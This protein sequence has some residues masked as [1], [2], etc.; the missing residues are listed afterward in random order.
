[1]IG[2]FWDALERDLK[3]EKMGLESTTEVVGEP[4]LSF[5]YDPKRS[6]YEQFSRAARESDDD[7][8]KS[9]ESTESNTDGR[10]S[11]DDMDT[12]ES[13]PT[14]TDVKDHEADT[15]DVRMSSSPD[16]EDGPKMRPGSA[17]L[18][19]KRSA[20]YF[21]AQYLML[22]E[23]NQ[24]SPNYKIRK[25]KAG[26]KGSNGL[27]SGVVSSARR[28]FD[29]ERAR[30]HGF[31]G[32][33]DGGMMLQFE[34]EI[35]REGDNMNA[36]EMFRLQALGELAPA[37]GKM[38][39]P[40]PQPMV[41][42]AEVYYHPSS[43]IQGQPFLTGHPG[44][45]MAHQ[46][47]RSHEAVHRHTF[48]S[49]GNS[50]NAFGSPQQL[51]GQSDSQDGTSM[52]RTKAFVCPLF[53]CGRMFKR[54]EH[55]KR[56]LRT[57]TMERPYACPRCKKR[58]SRSDNLNQHLR[59]HDRGGPITMHDNSSSDWNAID[60]LS[61]ADDHHRPG[62]LSRSSSVSGTESEGI[63]DLDPRQGMLGMYRGDYAITGEGLGMFGG[64]AAGMG[65]G[66]FG[67]AGL[68][69]SAVAPGNS[70]G[71]QF[72]NSGNSLGLDVHDMNMSNSD[73]EADG[74]MMRREMGGN[75]HGDAYGQGGDLY[76]LPHGKFDILF[77][78]ILDDNVVHLQTHNG[79]S[80]LSRVRRIARQGSLHHRE[81]FP[82]CATGTILPLATCPHHHHP[83]LPVIAMSLQ[84]RC[85]HL[86][87]NKHSNILC[88]PP[89]ILLR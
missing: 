25:K 48:P 33:G 79:L 27:A 29:Q 86:R 28:D 30:L 85:L 23:M 76:Y 61:D 74:M 78:A 49:A 56:H 87:I 18:S 65:M 80:V 26:V 67:M 82:W 36:A 24:G 11:P 64:A 81:Q 72:G 41:G 77:V 34:G 6:L 51:P 69:N 9:P 15:G 60:E 57:H 44:G 42:E 47:H 52:T 46:R 40:R 88:T 63:D 73:V 12:S 5:T 54:Q 1:M 39:T 84:P 3:R 2:F 31:S 55:L 45:I 10:I 22:F 71:P 20:R 17:A 8:R 75:D 43:N 83:P 37:D 58:F 35:K 14:S 7:E 4:A 62:R 32:M 59:T 21:G 68:G 13:S 66:Q 38:K 70:I 89:A 19:Q 53:S 50:S 16:S